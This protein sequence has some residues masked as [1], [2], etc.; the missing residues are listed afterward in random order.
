MFGPKIASPFLHRHSTIRKKRSNCVPRRYIYST[1]SIYQSLKAIPSNKNQTNLKHDDWTIASSKKQPKIQGPFQQC[2]KR[3]GTV[4]ISSPFW[5]EMNVPCGLQNCFGGGYNPWHTLLLTNVSQQLMVFHHLHV[6]L[7]TRKHLPKPVH[8]L[9]MK[10]PFGWPPDSSISVIAKPPGVQH[11][12]KVE[13]KKLGDSSGG[14]GRVYL[15]GCFRKIMVPP[16]HPICIGFSIINHSFWGT[17]IFGN[18]HIGI[19][20]EGCW[21]YGKTNFVGRTWNRREYNCIGSR[22]WQL[23]SVNGS[24]QC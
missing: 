17:P 22:C 16:N 6:R 1:Y 23:S 14:N 11:Q 24:T 12:K 8:F 20:V 21:G 19:L 15:Y 7:C 2:L 3:R 5:A 13:E 4:Q 9:L 18:I 10:A